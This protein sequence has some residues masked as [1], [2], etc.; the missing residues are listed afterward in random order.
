MGRLFQD[1]RQ[2]DGS[3]TRTYGGLGLGLSY[4]RRVAQAHRGEITAVSQEGRGSTF[5]LTLPVAPA[6]AVRPGEAKPKPPSKGRARTT[7]RSSSDVIRKKV[8]AARIPPRRRGK[9]KGSR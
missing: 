8:A 4:A 9:A 2:G 6:A 3:E 1:F 7:T 5:V